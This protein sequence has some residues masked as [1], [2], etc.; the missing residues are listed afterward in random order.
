MTELLHG[1]IL[2]DQVHST[3]M[4]TQKLKKGWH[5]S[6]SEDNISIK[7]NTGTTILGAAKNMI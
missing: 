3:D 6:K 4:N 1:K 5:T 2:F 7:G